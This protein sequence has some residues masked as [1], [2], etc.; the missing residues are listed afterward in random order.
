MKYFVFIGIVFALLLGL[1]LYPRVPSNPR[2]ESDEIYYVI[3]RREI[4]V[5]PAEGR[6]VP[7][8]ISDPVYVLANWAD[9]QAVWLVY[10]GQEPTVFSIRLADGVY[11]VPRFLVAEL[12]TGSWGIKI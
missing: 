12:R 8:N 11:A 6:V 1:G 3:F 10:C 9:V 2:Y 4:E 5:A 7:E